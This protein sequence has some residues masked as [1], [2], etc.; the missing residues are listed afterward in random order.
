MTAVFVLLVLFQLKH[1]LADYPLQRPWMLGKFKDKGWVLPLAAHAAVHGF[2]TWLIVCWFTTH[3]WLVALVV[4]LDVVLHF[5]M[6]RFKAGSKWMG[7]WKPLTG[8]QYTAMRAVLAGK[9]AGAPF[10]LE[11]A[12]ERLRGNTLFWWALGIDQMF[13]HLTHYLIIALILG[14]R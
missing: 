7:R 6:D 4:G 14:L 2:F 10:P 3:A 8:D 5:T 9:T 13:H 12:K 1:W 11:V